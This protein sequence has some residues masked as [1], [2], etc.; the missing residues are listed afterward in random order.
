MGVDTHCS[1]DWHGEQAVGVLDKNLGGDESNMPIE[2]GNETSGNCIDRTGTADSHIGEDGLTF[3]LNP[4]SNLGETTSAGVNGDDGSDVKSVSGKSKRRKRK[5]KQS[6]G[7]ELP[8]ITMDGDG[9]GLISN[10]GETISAGDNGNDCCGKQAVGVLDNILGGDELNMPFKGGNE[11]SGNCIGQNVMADSHVGEDGLTFHLNP[12]S[13]LDETTSAGVNGD[14]GYG[15]SISGKSKRRKWK[16]KQSGGVEL[17][18]VAVDANGLALISNVGQIMSAGDIGDDKRCGNDWPENAAVGI[19]D[20]NLG[21]DESNMP[22]V[23]GNEANGNCIAHN[24]ITDSHV[25][26][27]GLTLHLNSISGLGESACGNVGDGKSISGK[28]KRRKRKRKQSS[29][30]ELPAVSKD[31]NGLGLISNVVQTIDTGDDKRCSNGWPGMQAVGILDNNL[32]GNV[33]NM[34]IGGGNETNGNC[35]DCNGI[36]DSHIGEDGLTFPFSVS[37]LGQKTSAGVNGDDGG[38]GQSI[39]GKSKR[40]KR[41]RKQGSGVELPA[42]TMDANGL[43]LISNVGQ[44]VSAT[45]TADDKHC[46]N[47]W[48]EIQAAGVLD[49]NLCGDEPNMSIKGVNETSGSRI[50]GNGIVDG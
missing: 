40:R 13:D 6:S 10:V 5:R 34:P 30:V 35:I 1:N 37:N 17:P 14:V 33:S 12:I 18:A 24:G 7:V 46:S 4:I 22:V 28:S 49:N 27:D 48:P 16:R 32:G 19:S 36:T 44:S 2:G 50:D 39:H 45:N 29:G 21:G 23:S 41:K 20:N 9:V 47:G 26:E 8:D 31:G 25:G 3:H 43:A 38:D 11:T 15:K 42:A